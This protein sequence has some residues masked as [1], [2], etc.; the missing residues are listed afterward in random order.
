MPGKFSGLSS[1]YIGWLQS[2]FVLDKVF[3]T[4][5]WHT[6]ED[7]LLTFLCLLKNEVAHV[8]FNELLRASRQASPS[9]SISGQLECSLNGCVNE[10]SRPKL[11]RAFLRRQ[12]KT[13]L[14]DSFNLPELSRAINQQE[15]QYTLY[16][17]INFVIFSM[18]FCCEVTGDH[19]PP[20]SSIFGLIL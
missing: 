8:F 9:S 16:G 19:T 5:E 6:G 1:Y 7:M 20:N 18:S 13:Q 11:Y 12:E 15:C 4:N 2:L 10:I 17:L 14:K 3:L